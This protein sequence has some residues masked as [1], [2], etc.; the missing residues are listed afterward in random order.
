[1]EWEALTQLYPA[2]TRSRTRREGG[3]GGGESR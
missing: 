1:M 2:R 3:G